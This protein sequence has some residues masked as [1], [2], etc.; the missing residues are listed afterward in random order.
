M[1]RNKAINRAALELATTR[2]ALFML[3]GQSYGATG[4]F[5]DRDFYDTLLTAANVTR[6]IFF[7]LGES[8][9]KNRGITNLEQNAQLPKGQAF[10]ASHIGIRIFPADDEAGQTN[11][12]IAELYNN[13][14]TCYVEPFLSGKENMGSFSLVSFFPT[15]LVQPAAAA[16]GVPQSSH[17]MEGW[18]RFQVPFKVRENT[19]F[20]V[21]V[22]KGDQTNWSANIVDAF[23]IQVILRGVFARQQ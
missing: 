3:A 23:Y 21:R 1:D 9:A 10:S 5:L 16:L 2:E 7:A 18:R 14:R 13:L 6:M 20:G 12:V 4:D 15:M 11:A 17:V 8:P 19:G 22:V